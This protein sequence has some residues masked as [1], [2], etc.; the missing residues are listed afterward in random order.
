MIGPNAALYVDWTRSTKIGAKRAVY[1]SKNSNISDG[2]LKKRKCNR[3]GCG[4]GRRY[5][6]AKR[7]EVLE[8]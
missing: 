3:G 2:M 8:L 4:C 7:G 5:V 6:I 1:F